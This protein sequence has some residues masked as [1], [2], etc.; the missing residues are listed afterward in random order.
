MQHR[1]RVSNLKID[2]IAAALVAVSTIIIGWMFVIFAPELLTWLL[3]TYW[4]ISIGGIITLVATLFAFRFLS[5]KLCY[6]FEQELH[7]EARQSLVD[8]SILLLNQAF[9]SDDIKYMRIYSDVLEKHIESANRETENGSLK[10]MSVMQRV[11][12]SSEFLLDK[13]KDSERNADQLKFLQSERLISNQALLDEMSQY[14]SNKSAQ[15]NQDNDRIQ[16]VLLQVKGLTG[17]TGLIRNIAKQTNL[18]ALN[19][20]IEAARAGDAG[21]GFAVVADK[22]R[23]LSQETESATSEIDRAIVS[24][25]ETVEKNLSGV[26]D[27]DQTRE[28]LEKIEAIS[29]SLKSILTDF[30]SVSE[31][32]TSLSVDSR[33]AM[34]AVH[35][36]IME[37]LGSMQ[38]QDISRQQ[39]DSVKILLSEMVNHFWQLDEYLRASPPIGIKAQTLEKLLESHRDYYVMQQQHDSHSQALGDQTTQSSTASIEL[40]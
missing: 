3:K 12:G 14:A 10:I 15:V 18:L 4:V 1:I 31:Y 28:E 2:L 37:V 33:Q 35:D 22:I 17:L 7:R 32:L 6:R 5:Q 29:A 26:L 27:G 34:T 30:T 38:F 23:S 13:L 19:A 20:S 24:V 39:L 25:S 36:G 40:F 21:R 8:H 9:I 16:E 11:Y